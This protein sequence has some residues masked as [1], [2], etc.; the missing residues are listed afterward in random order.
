MKLS[1]NVLVSFALIQNYVRSI[2]RPLRKETWSYRIPLRGKMNNDSPLYWKV[3]VMLWN[4]PIPLTFKNLIDFF[5]PCL[6]SEEHTSELQS[7][8]DLVCRLL[9]EKKK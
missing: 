9:L 6:R 3:P 5:L 2:L 8:S 4:I 1:D 7:H